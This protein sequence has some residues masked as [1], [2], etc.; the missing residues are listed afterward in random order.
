MPEIHS[1][2][3]FS[4]LS[5]LAS[6]LNYT[7]TGFQSILYGLSPAQR[8]FFVLLADEGTADT[9]RVRTA[10]SVGNPSFT[11][12]EINA[13]LQAAGDPRRVVCTLRPHINRYGNAGVLGHWHIVTVPTEAA[14]DD[15]DQAA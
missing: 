3:E 7:P 9:I 4:Q 10:C 15:T 5:G 13:K 14:N 8:R 1:E 11:A 6:R 12:S 2:P